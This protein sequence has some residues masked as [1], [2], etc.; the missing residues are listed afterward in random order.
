MNIKRQTDMQTERTGKKL[1]TLHLL[2]HFDLCDYTYVWTRFFSSSFTSF[3]LVRRTSRNNSHAFKKEKETH[4]LHSKNSL[5]TQ[6][7]I[8]T[9][10]NFWTGSLASQWDKT[11]W[12]V[13][14]TRGT[15]FIT[16]VDGSCRPAAIIKLYHSWDVIFYPPLLQPPSLVGVMGG[17]QC[18]VN[19]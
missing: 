1:N 9:S 11:T 7:R 17:C 19:A 10:V 2:M 13:H 8:T 14:L 4:F 16:C 18:S 3:S 15:L 5:I 6:Q 12:I